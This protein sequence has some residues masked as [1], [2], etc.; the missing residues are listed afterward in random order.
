MEDKD[1]ITKFC[2]IA[3]PIPVRRMLEKDCPNNMTWGVYLQTLLKHS[4]HYR[5]LKRRVKGGKER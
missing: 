4:L 2:K 5:R 3:V 1:R